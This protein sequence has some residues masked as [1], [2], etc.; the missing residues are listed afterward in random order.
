MHQQGLRGTFLWASLLT[1][2]VIWVGFTAQPFPL[3]L[4]TGGRGD[5]A[6]GNC[7][8]PVNTWE[9]PLAFGLKVRPWEHSATPVPSIP[10]FNYQR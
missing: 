6:Q 5:E 2:G 4:R 3:V 9:V 1:T 7:S 10:I 8:L